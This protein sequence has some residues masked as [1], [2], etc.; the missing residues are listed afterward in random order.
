MGSDSQ[1]TVSQVRESVG[2]PA[3]GTDFLGQK[4]CAGG[5][6]ERV[7]KGPRRKDWA[8]LSQV[9][10]AHPSDPSFVFVSLDEMGYL[11]W[12][13]RALGTPALKPASASSAPSGVRGDSLMRTPGGHRSPPLPASGRARYHS[14]GISSWHIHTECLRHRC[15]RLPF[16]EK[17]RTPLQQPCAQAC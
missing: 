16:T 12:L 6:S 13:T 8:F 4:C 2:H 11:P 1:V 15:G 7:K 17:N 9:H 10:M 3:G 14:P 5:H